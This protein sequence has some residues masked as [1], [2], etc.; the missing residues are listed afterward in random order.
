M[1]LLVTTSHSVLLVDGSSGDAKPVH[2]GQGLYFGIAS[3]G[4]HF[5]VA[6][7]GRMVSS[8][9]PA[10]EENGRI[11]VFDPSLRLLEEIAAPFAL[12]DMHEIL[13]HAGK[14]WITCSF[15]NMVAVYEPV[16]GHWDRWYPLGP[17]AAPPYDL[18]HFNSFGIVDGALAIVAHNWGESEVMRFETGGRQLLSR[19]LLGRQAHNLRM[20]EGE[21]L[22]TCSSAEGELVATSGWQLQVGGFPRGLILGAHERYVGI[23]EIAERQDRDLTTGRIAVYDEGW[24]L[25]RTLLFPQEGLLL[26]LAV[27]TP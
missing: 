23:S 27:Y 14:L 2:R 9:V 22:L 11:L 1:K 15:D 17:T 26:E 21:G 13:W 25:Q 20:L 12:R 5:F 8:E 24:N 16:S 3:D 6:A 18:N 10:E 19:Q 4:E 7:R